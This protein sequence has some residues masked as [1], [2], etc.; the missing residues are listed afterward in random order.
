MTYTGKKLYKSS[1][2]KTLC[3]VL[4]GVAEYFEIDPTLVRLG[5]VLLSIF[6]AAFPGVIGYIVMCIVM[7]SRPTYQQPYNRQQPSYNQPQPPY[8]QPQ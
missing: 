8:N 4:G 7:P 5:Y 6:F 1:T 3:G 2:D